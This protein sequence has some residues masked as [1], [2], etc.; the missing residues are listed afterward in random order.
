MFSN[1]FQL[2]KYVTGSIIKM[3]WQRRIHG[4]H[5]WRRYS[6]IIHSLIEFLVYKFLGK[7]V[8]CFNTVDSKY[9]KMRYIL[10]AQFNIFY[11]YSIIG[12]FLRFLITISTFSWVY[13]VSPLAINPTFEITRKP[14]KFSGITRSWLAL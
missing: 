13:V 4:M 14:R 1:R 7:L 3:K 2:R 9:I 8:C 12:C 10:Y 5:H 11:A 6:T